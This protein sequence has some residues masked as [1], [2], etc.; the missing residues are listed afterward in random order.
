MAFEFHLPDIG[1][2]LAEAT[3][4]A[5]R[6]PVGG[7]VGLDEPLVEVET[8]K[9][10]VEIP[11]PRAGVV[12][13]HGAPEG[14]TLLVD[15]LLVVIGEPGE[16]WSPAEASAPAEP[17]SVSATT[18]PAAPIVGTLEEATETVGEARDGRALALPVVRRLAFELGVDLATVE[19]TGPGGRITR[20]DVERAMA[21]G[22]PVDRVR[23]SAT[24]LAIARNLTR[25]WQEIPHVTTYAAANATGLLA[26]RSR[27]GAD[28]AMP[29]EALLIS[30]LVPLLREFPE[31][32]ATL[33]GEYVLYRRHYD[34]GFAVD[35]PDGLMV[36]VVREADDRTV[37]EI[38]HEVLRLAG[39]VRQ[40]RATPADLRGATFTVS[41]IGAVGGGYG[42][43]I[44]P[45]GT[46]AIL[47]VGR[48]E[49]VPVESDGAITMRRQLPL[50]LSYDH[51]L[52]DG[53]LGRRFLGSI[54]EAIEARG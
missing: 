19:G 53:A 37:H 11:S 24:R 27:L 46:T 12:L 41:N 29:L 10:V 7:T 21:G 22:G 38:A 28:R 20:E 40:R 13:H 42:T 18:R 50:S 43:P 2:G 39:A 15:S 34:I 25:S 52:I 45:Y 17:A 44:I 6:V 33:D 14:A 9:A 32:N 26:E 47:S 23:L 3:I 35:T 31:F 54:V 48:A 16:S 36:A 30:A 51:R 49:P 8:D 4:V 5:W 1:E